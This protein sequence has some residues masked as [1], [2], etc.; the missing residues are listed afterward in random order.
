MLCIVDM[1]M[2]NIYFKGFIFDIL[3]SVVISVSI[4]LNIKERMVRGIV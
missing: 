3:V 4:I 2:L 1:Y